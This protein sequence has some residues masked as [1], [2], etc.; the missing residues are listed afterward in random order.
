MAETPFRVR[1]DATPSPDPA[2]CLT[3]PWPDLLIAAL[4]LAGL[5]SPLITLFGAAGAFA[6][7]DQDQGIVLAGAGL[8]HLVLRMTLL[9]GV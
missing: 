5:V 2:R 3:Q 6:V 8:M 9:A 1:A 4:V 7:A